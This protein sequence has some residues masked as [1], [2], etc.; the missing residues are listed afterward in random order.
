MAEEPEKASKTE[1]PS[2]KRLSDAR[3]SGD[4]P[5][6]PDVAPLFALATASAVTLIYGGQIARSIAEQL[7]PFIAHPDTIDLTGNGGQ[8]VYLLAL[9]ACMPVLVVLLA[10]AVAG[11]VGHIAQQGFIWAPSKLSPDLAKL[12]PM[13]GIERLF[14][15]DGLMQSLKSMLK[16]AAVCVITW[17]IVAPKVGELRMMS[18]LNVAAI[19]PV[20]IDLLRQ[21]IIAVIIFLSALAGIDWFWQRQRFMTRMRMTKEE[22]KQEAKDSDGDPHVKA[23]RRQIQFERAKRRM[24]Q[25]VP[26]ATVVVMN[27]THYAVALRYVQGETAAPICV[28]KGM[29]AV[30]LKIREIAEKAGV[31]VIEDAPLAR[32]LYATVEV[33]EAIPREHFEAVAKVIGFLLAKARE[34]FQPGR[35]LA[36]TGGR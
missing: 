17:M 4:V 12:S 1:E 28:A 33:D 2:G 19:L 6:S 7:L 9:K 27:P 16:L 14:G 10:T 21:L 36:A 3:A 13:K 25:N 24:M 29:D 35:L 15:L 22:V 11:A 20:T 26:N 34:R 31:A 8:M 32:A 5:K 18:G 30:A 23:R